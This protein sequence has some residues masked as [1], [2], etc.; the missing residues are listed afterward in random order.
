[1]TLFLVTNSTTIVTI[2]DITLAIGFQ[3][4]WPNLQAY[5]GYF[6][7]SDE[8]LNRIWYSGAYTLQTNAVPVNYGREVP[9]VVTGWSNNGLLGPGDTIIV[10]GAKRDRA[11]WPG[12]MFIA[13]PSTFVSI[14]DLASVKN[15]LQTMY[16]NQV[17][18]SSFVRST[19]C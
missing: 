4:T 13:V 16:N 6:H 8:L 1:M 11:V 18:D 2:T 14:G 9:F 3:P 7:S 15:A 12:D 5:Q 10:D 17:Y 19:L